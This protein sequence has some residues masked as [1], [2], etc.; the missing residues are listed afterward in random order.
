[1]ADLKISA[2]TASTTPLAGTEVL[3]IVQ[4]G[5]TVKV[6][7]ANLTAGRAT[8]ALS[9]AF[10]TGT[11][12]FGY[13]GTQ[14]SA[15]NTS[16]NTYLSIYGG[17]G[18][19]NGG[20]LLGGNNTENQ[21]NVLWVE[22]GN[23]LQIAS[24]PVSSKIKIIAA[25]VDVGDFT[26][27]GYAPSNGKGID[28]SATSGSGTSELLADYEEGTWTPTQ[29]SG[30]TVVGTFSSVGVYTKIGRQ[31]TVTAYLNGST[32][33]VANAGGAICGGLPFTATG[34]PVG[35]MGTDALNQG[36]TCA[37]Y[38]NNIWACTTTTAATG[39]TAT[40]TYTV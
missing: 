2:L 25:G 17:A 21:A 3:P 37:A 23:Y 15:T 36:G 35:S 33:I 4:S 16:A 22:S 10:G 31:V 11:N 1:M 29:L 24:N 5:A 20:W 13:G 26:T 7:V 12:A 28:F 19:T 6:S 38:V 39:V 30:L 9:G 18:S 27:N 14:V 34:A 32:S 8:S 40:I